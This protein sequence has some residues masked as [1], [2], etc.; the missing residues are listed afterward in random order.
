MSNAISFRPTYAI[1]DLSAIQKNVENL[2]CHVT[3]NAE[4]IAVVKAN[5]YGHG[6]IAVSKVAL[7]A[8][9]TMLAVATPE[10]ALHIREIIKEVPIIILGAVPVSFV[11]Y[12]ARYNITLTVFSIDWIITAI[13]Q[14]TASASPVK[15]HLKIDSGMGRLG[16]KVTKDLKTL[17]DAIHTSSLFELDGIFTHFATADE[18]DITYYEQQK[19][20]FI[21]MVDNLPS[22]P[23]LVH[24]ANTAAALVK[25]GV[26]FDA[27][28]L[29]ISMYGLSPSQYVEKHL[30]YPLQPALQLESEIVHVKQLQ[31]GESVGYGATYK[32]KKDGEWIATLP[33]GYADGLLRG[34]EGQEVLVGGQRAEIVGRICMDQVMI[35]LSNEMKS[36]EPVVLIGKQGNDEIT[37][38]EW[39][40]RL[41]TIV[42]EIACML[43]SRV[44]RVYKTSI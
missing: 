35:R 37:M 32:A 15:V 1:I 9:A 5:A 43:T 14:F 40:D 4:I 30:T 28:R 19:N 38:Q 44:T 7:D 17:Y 42:Y 33:I 39:A 34:L 26:E 10:E 12:A 31:K 27:I 29:G 16:V 24:A 20:K 36:G 21:T 2:K 18:E 25:S 22:R 23:R 6:D 3:T 11:P 8:G 41:Q 13:Q